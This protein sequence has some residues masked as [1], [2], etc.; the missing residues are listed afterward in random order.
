M[1]LMIST[2]FCLAGTAVMLFVAFRISGSNRRSLRILNAHRIGVL[3]TIQRGRMDLIEM[4]NRARLLEE[5]V[6]GGATAVEK[7]HKAIANTTF[8]L[9][10]LLTRDDEFR[11]SA[12]RIHQSHHQKS[13]KVYKAVRTT[14]RALHIL[15]DTLVIGRAEKRIVSK[16]KKAP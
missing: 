10:D 1:L 8:G 15:A 11:N 3:S 4:R 12:R 7:V 16:T 14:N 5:A 2:T 9:I 6:S 13:E